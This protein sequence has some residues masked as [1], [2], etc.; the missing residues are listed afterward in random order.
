M[1]QEFQSVKT[2][3]DKCHFSEKIYQNQQNFILL[4][5]EI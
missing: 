4:S 1:L 3:S 2:L 5:H